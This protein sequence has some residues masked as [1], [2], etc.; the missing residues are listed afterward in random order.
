MR[1]DDDGIRP[2]PTTATA[3]TAASATAAADHA[4]GDASRVGRN[5]AAMAGGQLVTWSMS[6]LWTLVVP[7][8]LGPAGMGIVVAAWSVTGV[9]GLLLG[10]GTRNYLVREMVVREGEA[11]R[12]LGTAIVL[13]LALSPLLVG[14][15]LV[16]AQVADV[17]GDAKLVLYLAVAATIFT[18]IAEPMQAAFQAIE[19]M[20]YIA[21]SEVIN[22]SAQG[23]VGIAL[24]I[25]G[26][27]AIGITASWAA[28]TGMVIVL[29][30]LWIG[31]RM[32]IDLRTSV[33]RLA[34]M[35]RQSLAYWAFGVFFT[36][37]LW[38]DALMLSLMTR[39]E[40]VGWYGV[41]M[42]LFQTF[43]FLPVVISMAWLPRLVRAYVAEGPDGL[44]AAARRPLEIVLVLSLPIG[45]AI[46]ISAGPVVRTLYGADYEGSAPVL[47]VLGLCIA[48][49]Y[50]NI[51]LNQVLVAAKRQIAW[52]WVMAGATVLNPLLNAVL[53]PATQ[54]RYDNG[55]IG[56]GVSL[57]LTEIAIVSVGFV[58]VGS[59]VFDRPLL[60][61]VVLTALAS[62]AMCLVAWA[63]RPVGEIASLALGAA[64]LAILATPLR[65][66][67]PDELALARRTV[68]RVLGR[69]VPARRRS[70]ATALE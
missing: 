25:L 70:A 2:A 52:T 7:R 26:F 34:D 20:K 21:Y 33:G 23:L 4:P 46:A 11:P 43:M 60:R 14:G 12:L 17:G 13:R 10:L 24:A 5:I 51:M 39:P 68:R 40:V 41:P 45:A 37:Y 54:Q 64:T 38:I 47:A 62:A 66:V 6:L 55:A 58:L 31:R 42:K 9:L 49:M 35:V 44:R 16:Y 56:A 53:I 29:N 67:T 3:V 19:R 1:S 63:T 28:M 61:R 69:I 30:V 8:A 48:P 32:R 18:Q 27:G 15:A 57:L 50:V 59:A 65:L 36:I 22:K